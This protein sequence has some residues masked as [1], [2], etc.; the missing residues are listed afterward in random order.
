MNLNPLGI[1]PPWVY[2]AGAAGLS[3]VAFS[4][5]VIITRNFYKAGEVDA[6]KERVEALQETDKAKDSLIEQSKAINE[7]TNQQMIRISDAM[8]DLS[9]RQPKHTERITETLRDAPERYKDED[10]DNCLT[11]RYPDGLR[12]EISASIESHFAS[13]P[14]FDS[15]GARIEYPTLTERSSKRP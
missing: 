13:L 1:I 15:S 6:L 5:G 10:P 4:S 2:L 14:K 3:T 8:I 12:N 11:Y 7:Q 9:A